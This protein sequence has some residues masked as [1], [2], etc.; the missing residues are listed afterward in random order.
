MSNP[1]HKPAAPRTKTALDERKLQLSAMPI[2]KG[3]KPPSLMVNL[4]RNNPQLTV[5]PNHDNG[6][7]VTMIGAGMDLNTFFL[8][9][10]AI[11]F[12]CE[13]STKPGHIDIENMVPIPKEERTDPKVRNRVKNKTRIRKDD[14]GVISIG[15]ID[16]NQSQ[17]P[18]IQFPFQVNYY[19]SVKSKTYELSKAD[20]S[21]WVAL[22]WCNTFEQLVASV[23]VQNGL[24][25]K[26][27]NQGNGG[28][29]NGY[30]NKGNSN[31]QNKGQSNGN[32]A[33]TAY[34]DFD[35]GDFDD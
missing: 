31:Y 14:E 24:D 20:T 18:R 16:I 28:Q 2:E 22:A 26:N 23:I 11:R 17:A 21:R 5:F 13:P 34:N 19:H 12:I 30:Q 4:Y 10:Q 8:L 29:N 6:S 27:T 25:Q 1:Y 15:V 35:D 3:A 7:G 33:Q 32:A 9:M